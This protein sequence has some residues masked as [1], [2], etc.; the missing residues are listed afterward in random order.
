MCARVCFILKFILFMLLCCVLDPN[1][2]LIFCARTSVRR[3]SLEA[4]DHS[5]VVLVQYLRNA[6]SVDF[7]WHSK[8]MYWSDVASDVI[9]SANFDGSN[10]QD[11]IKGNISTPDGIAVDWIAGNIYWTDTG[12]DK[13]EVA[14]LNGIHRKVIVSQNLDEPRAI[15]LFPRKG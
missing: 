7:H 11:V 5:D 15:C 9:M 14:R 10:Q 1:K 12:T 4:P 6:I 8:R 3:I 2:F 13:I